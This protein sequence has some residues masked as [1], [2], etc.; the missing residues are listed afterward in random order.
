MSESF[1]LPTEPEGVIPSLIE[2]FNSGKVEAMMALY[3][4]EAVFIAK[5]GRT[6]TDRTEIAAQ[7]QR[8]MSLGLPLKANVR[9]VFVGVDTAQIVV[10][11]S[12][13]GTGPDGKPVKVLLRSIDVLHDFYVPEFRA[14]MDMIP[15]MVTYFWLTPT[16]TGT[17]EIL[18]AELCGVGHPQMRGTVV[19]DNDADY[20]TWLGQQ[21]TFTQLTASSGEPPPAN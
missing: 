16:R 11:W 14:K 10:D 9:H 20:Q 19:V 7:F 21:Q 5:D 12:I 15:G 13:D 4:P 2:R 6:I 18:C 1:P 17:F 3:A 8:D